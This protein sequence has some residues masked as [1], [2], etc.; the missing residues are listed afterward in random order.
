MSAEDGLADTLRHRLDRA[1][2]NVERI[3]ALTGW[4]SDGGQ[5]GAVS[6]KDVDILRD[7]MER[8]KPRLVI[9]DPVQAYLGAGVDMHRANEV[10]PILTG[11]CRNRCNRKRCIVAWAQLILPLRPG[12]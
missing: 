12:Q 4:R 5:S 3:Y 10:R 11:L 7:A 1:G 6:L 2:A 9:V 8:I